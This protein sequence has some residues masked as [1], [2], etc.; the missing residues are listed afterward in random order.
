LPLFGIDSKIVDFRPKVFAESTV[1][2]LDRPNPALG[3]VVV[4]VGTSF[5][6]S[7]GISDPFSIL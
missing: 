1:D 4:I 6:C 2:C 5:E 3:A 7:T